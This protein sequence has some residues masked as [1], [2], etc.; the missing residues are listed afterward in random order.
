MRG[1]VRVAMDRKGRRLFAGCGNKMMAI[2][3]ADTGLVIATPAI[4]EGVDANGFDPE[5]SLAFASTGEGTLNVVREE[6]P[7]KFTP[8]GSVTDEEK[9][10]HHGPRPQDP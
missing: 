3:D 7:S 10:P 4:G 5:T 6:S 8:V 1:T 2:V 9:R